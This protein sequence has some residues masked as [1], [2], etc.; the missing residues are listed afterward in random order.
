MLSDIEF[1]SKSGDIM[2]YN[3][4]PGVMSLPCTCNL[5]YTSLSY[6]GD[7]LAVSIDTDNQQ[8]DYRAMQECLN[9]LIKATSEKQGL[10]YTY[11]FGGY[12]PRYEPSHLPTIL[13][14]CT[15]DFI[16]FYTERC[17]SSI[18]NR[19]WK[20]LEYLRHKPQRT[21]KDLNTMDSIENYITALLSVLDY[22]IQQSERCKDI[23]SALH[24][25]M[26]ILM[27]PRKDGSASGMERFLVPD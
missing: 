3:V 25:V 10:G 7:G 19:A 1:T 9:M 18:V 17:V 6:T 26:A 12:R 22:L 14:F 8:W 13:I 16:A 4:V 27:K 15:T 2:G 5:S 23:C 21:A 11:S 24:V 20:M